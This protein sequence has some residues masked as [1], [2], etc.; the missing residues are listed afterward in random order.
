MNNPNF[1][2]GCFLWLKIKGKSFLI[3][4]VTVTDRNNKGSFKYDVHLWGGGGWGCLRKCDMPCIRYTMKRD[5]VAQGKRG[6]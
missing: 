4:E 5:G 2:R 3:N 6:F 1:M